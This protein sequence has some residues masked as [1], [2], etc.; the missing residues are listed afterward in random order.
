MARN[1]KI[2]KYAS[3]KNLSKTFR[4]I[5]IDLTTICLFRK[6]SRRIVMNAFY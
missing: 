5:T 1:K 4:L 6:S 2:W 3:P